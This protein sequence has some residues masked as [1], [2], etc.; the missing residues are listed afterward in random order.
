MTA[1]LY[2]PSGAGLSRR[3]DLSNIASLFSEIEE[4]P[5]TPPTNRLVLRAVAAALLVLLAFGDTMLVNRPDM[6]TAPASH[7]S[8][9]GTG[10]A[11]SL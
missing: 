9:A 8:L 7:R 5:K 4:Q 1:F 3:V 2:I 11:I 6:L 10:P